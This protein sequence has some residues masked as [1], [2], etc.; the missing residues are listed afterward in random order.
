MLTFPCFKFLSWRP[1]L[2]GQVTTGGQATSGQVQ[3]AQTDGGGRWIFELVDASL[4]KRLQ[5]KAWRAFEAILDGGVTEVILML[6]DRRQSPGFANG[7][8][9]GGIPHSDGSLFS[10]G[11]GYSQTSGST[12]LAQAAAR[13]ATTLTLD[14]VEGIEG[15]ENFSILHEV[16]GWRLYRLATVEGNQ[17]TFRPPLREAI[18]ASTQLEFENPRCVVRLFD[19]EGYAPTVERLRYARGTVTFMESFDYDS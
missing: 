3:T 1:R 11:S 13:R 7:Q 6:C 15:G 9:T 19:P 16:A 2:A 5:L 4:N 8:A 14:S 12:F 17:I 10:D 18:A